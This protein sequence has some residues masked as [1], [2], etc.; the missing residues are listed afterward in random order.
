[1]IAIIFSLLI[2]SLFAIV[3]DPYMEHLPAWFFGFLAT[4]CLLCGCFL[5]VGVAIAFWMYLP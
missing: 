1:M 4:A 2:V 3:C 5:A